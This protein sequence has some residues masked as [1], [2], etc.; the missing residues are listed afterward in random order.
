MFYEYT[1]KVNPVPNKTEVK[2]ELT[3]IILAPIV[4]K[5]RGPATRVRA[6]CFVAELMR[7][8]L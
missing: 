1:V 4:C 2:P 6:P 8:V 3:R 5:K 7:M